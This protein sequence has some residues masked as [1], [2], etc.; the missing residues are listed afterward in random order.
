MDLRTLIGTLIE[1]ADKDADTLD[2]L[3]G[4]ASGDDTRENY[5]AYRAELD[6][7]NAAIKAGRA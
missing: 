7:T 3:C 4:E 6:E 1:A 5:E 2:E